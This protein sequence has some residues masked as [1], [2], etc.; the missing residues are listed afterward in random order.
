M[1]IYT[2][3]SS[4]INI[5]VKAYKKN[6]KWKQRKAPKLLTVLSYNNYLYLLN[7]IVAKKSA[8]NANFAFLEY[9]S[10]NAFELNMGHQ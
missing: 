1:Y 6:L 4:I 8:K 9:T 10:F 3:V 2:I 5:D 7:K